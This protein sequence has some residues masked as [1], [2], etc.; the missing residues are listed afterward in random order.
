MSFITVGPNECLVVSGMSSPALLPPYVA[1]HNPAR[2]PQPHSPAFNSNPATDC[3]SPPAWRLGP[4]VVHY[5]KAGGGGT[6]YLYGHK[7]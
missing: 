5:A 2:P 6:A 1:R 7:G 4:G 3:D